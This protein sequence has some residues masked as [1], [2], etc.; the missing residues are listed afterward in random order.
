[1]QFIIQR[2]VE[3]ILAAVLF[4]GGLVGLLLST[5]IENPFAVVYPLAS[6]L[7][8]IIYYASLDCNKIQLP[9]IRLAAKP[10]VILFVFTFIS[11]VAIFYASDFNRIPVVLVLTLLLYCIAVISLFTNQPEVSLALLLLA[12]I[13][14]RATMV[15]SSPIPL[16]NDSLYHMR[17]GMLIAETG[18]LEPLGHSDNPRYFYAPVFHVL[19]ALGAL[20][21]QFTSTTVGFLVITIPC[22]VIP[23]IIA[24]ELGREFGVKQYGFIAAFLYLTSDYAVGWSVTPQP[25]TL[26]IIFFSMLFYA[27]IRYYRQL[28]GAGNHSSDTKLLLALVPIFIALIFMHHLTTFVSL[29]IVSLYLLCRSSVDTHRIQ[30]QSLPKMWNFIVLIWFITATVWTFTYYRG[31]FGSDESFV[32]VA[33]ADIILRLV[34][35]SYGESNGP[36]MVSDFWLT[37][38]DALT[39]PHIIGGGIFFIFASYGTIILLRVNI[40]KQHSLAIG[41]TM[42]TGLAITFAGPLVGFRFFQPQRWFLFMFFVF[43]LPAAIGLV[44]LANLLSDNKQVMAVTIVLFLTVF[45]GVMGTS[46]MGSIDDPIQSEAPGAQQFAIS[47]TDYQMFQWA[48]N[49]NNSVESDHLSAIVV[50]NHFGGEASTLSFT[51]DGELATS[52]S[53]YI[54]ERPYTRTLQSSYYLSINNPVRGYGPLPK[55]P[56]NCVYS[57]KI[58]HSGDNK[59][60][61]YRTQCNNVNTMTSN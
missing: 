37:G 9:D 31:P 41:I 58:Y 2:H 19:I 57:S 39:I 45:A 15:A 27:S 29:V 50:Q 28:R 38:A 48:A 60:G 12:A 22:V 56:L 24:F 51:P 21:T 34:N 6:V 59:I 13:T 44:N 7:T 30:E 16:G 1:M 52:E 32:A 23:G 25:T 26:G 3:T 5:E 8:G 61:S 14:H 17:M 54:M 40:R 11:L 4:F 47:E 18:G 36:I 10:V 46:Y 33:A 53:V 42:W 55:I 43:A 35:L 20:F 49:K